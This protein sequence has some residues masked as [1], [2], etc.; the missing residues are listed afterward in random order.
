MDTI[1]GIDPIEP[2]WKSNLKGVVEFLVETVKVIIVSLAIILPVRYFLIQP[3]YVRG[4]SMEPNFYD[5]EYLIIDELSYRFNDPDRGDIVV[6]R[7]PKDPRQYFIKRIIG[8]PG[9]KVEIVGG[10]ILIYNDGNPLGKLLDESVYLSNGLVTT[11]DL[12]TIL[13]DNEYFVMGDNRQ[14]S[15][16]SRR[17]GPIKRSNII[18]KTWFRGWPFDRVGWFETPSY[19]F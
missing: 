1:I 10:E 2:K 14:F 8:L 5:H 17:F 7:Y 6:F 15:L 11:P 19:N 3:F 18:G 12:T 4:A 9:E 13:E 16:D